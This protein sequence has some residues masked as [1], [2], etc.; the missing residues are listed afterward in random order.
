MNCK[1]YKIGLSPHYAFTAG[2]LLWASLILLPVP[3]W[4]QDAEAIVKKADEHMR[5]NTTVVELTI[6]TIRPTWSRSLELKAWM[7]GADYSMILIQAPA[8]EKGIVFLKRRKEVWNWMPVLERNI[9]L[10]PSMMSQS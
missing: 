3:S 7:K 1:R 2:V 6:Q 9:K 8:K 5:G 4:S 10:P